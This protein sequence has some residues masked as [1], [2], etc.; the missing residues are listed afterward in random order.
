[1]AEGRGYNKAGKFTH[2]AGLGEF[3][4]LKSYLGSVGY[5]MYSRL[6]EALQL[7]YPGSTTSNHI[8]DGECFDKAICAHLLIDIAIYRTP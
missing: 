4:L 3:H 1:M 2:H 5:I 8:L 7:I 6:L